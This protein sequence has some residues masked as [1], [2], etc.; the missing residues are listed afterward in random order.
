MQ[1]LIKEIR[2]CII[3]KNVY[4]Y[5]GYACKEPATCPSKECISK[6]QW[7]RRKMNHYNSS[8]DIVP[9]HRNIIIGLALKDEGI[10]L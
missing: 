7:A 6:N 8:V 1:K 10:Y 2:T 4:E 3:C 5:F 9:E